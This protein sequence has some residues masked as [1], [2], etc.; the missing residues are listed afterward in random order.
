MGHLSMQAHIHVPL[1]VGPRMD[2]QATFGL[3]GQALNDT[4]DLLAVAARVKQT[5][6][7]AILLDAKGN[8]ASGPIDFK[9]VKKGHAFRVKGVQSDECWIS[10]GRAAAMRG[11]LF[12]ELTAVKFYSFEVLN[13]FVRNAS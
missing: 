1:D 6:K 11:G 8:D 4:D 3:M 13:D 7:Y 5:K 10:I 12:T 9:E 2:I